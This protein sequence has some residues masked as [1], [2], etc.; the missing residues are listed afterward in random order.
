MLS[1]TV[2]SSDALSFGHLGRSDREIIF[3]GTVGVALSRRLVLGWDVA[4]QPGGM[5]TRSGYGLR[6][7][8]SSGT[9]IQAGVVDCAPG[10]DNQFSMNVSHAF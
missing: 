10:Y 4:E 8:G 7:T 1:A 2:R 3:G 9:T 5:Q 6:Y